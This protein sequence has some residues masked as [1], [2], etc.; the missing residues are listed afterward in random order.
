ML[1]SIPLAHI[2]VFGR[3]DSPLSHGGCRTPSTSPSRCRCPSRWLT[4]LRTAKWP[5]R[6]SPLWTCSA[7]TTRRCSPTA[8]YSWAVEPSWYGMVKLRSVLPPNTVVA[9]QRVWDFETLA[10]ACRLQQLGPGPGV[11]MVALL[12]GQAGFVL[13]VCNGAYRTTPCPALLLLPLWPHLR[14]RHI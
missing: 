7:T 13:G 4:S 8:N 3:A 11:L 10:V 1:L 6:T 12:K 14:H 2:T 5:R 9:V